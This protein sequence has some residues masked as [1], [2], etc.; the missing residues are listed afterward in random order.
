[1]PDDPNTLP[2]LRLGRLFLSPELRALQPGLPLVVTATVGVPDSAA[3]TAACPDVAWAD[4]ARE[5]GE[6]GADSGPPRPSPPV[7]GTPWSAAPGL[8]SRRMARSCW[9]G[10]SRTERRP[11]GPG[12]P[13]AAPAPGGRVRGTPTALC[14]HAG[15]TGWHRDHRARQRRRA[16]SQ[17]VPPRGPPSR[18]VP[19]PRSGPAARSAARRTARDRPGARERRPAERRVHRRAGGRGCGQRRRAHRPRPGG[20]A[21]HRRGR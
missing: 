12:R 6:L 15:R 16:A 9:P 1:M 19:R 21:H 5:A 10:G 8:R 20:S 18:P 4:A 2:L 11:R 7:P 13:A 3:G 17:A 14:G